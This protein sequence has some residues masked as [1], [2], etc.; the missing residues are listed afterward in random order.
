MN[1]LDI[2]HETY[3]ALVA[4]KVRTGLTMLGIVI[5]ISSVIAMVSIGQ[6]AQ[7]TIE[8]SIQSIGANLIMISP[9]AQA[10]VGGYQARSAGGSI[11]TLTSEDAL[12]I[13]ESVAGV[14][15]VTAELSGRYQVVA[16]GTNTNTSVVG[17]TPTY[18]EVRNIKMA[19]GAFLSD[20][21]VRTR[22]KVAVLGP[23]VRDTLFG[24]GAEAVGKTVRV[25]GMEFIVIGVTTAKGGSGFSNADDTMFIPLSSAQ[26][27]LAG[28]EHVSSISVQ[29]TDASVMT[30]AQAE[31]SAI[32]LKRHKIT[33]PAKADFSILNQNDIVATASSV[34]GIFTIL[35][36]AVAGISLV[37]GG[38]GIMN[39]ML[40]TV[41]ERTREIGLRKAIGAKKRDI[42][43]QFLFEA[44]A[45]TVVGG[46]IGVIIGWGI[47][48]GISYFNIIDTSVSLGS[49]LLA[50]GVS[51]FIGIVFGYYPAKRAA[52]L[53]PIEALRYE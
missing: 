48:F 31:V 39:M 18:P 15:S 33:D 51:A 11:R 27:F 35:L 38:I 49:V 36:G 47:S 17:T 30:E 44:I 13:A 28:S 14:Q 21:Q 52:E 6:G 50:F 5:G 22:A 2:L 41:T 7:K 43:R 53:N 4:N 34:T 46:T 20:L 9:G 12:A 8:T 29:A 23:T 10:S 19:E 40:T 16:K 45:L 25:N 32:L 26:Q 42:S 24:E 3:S 37:V 1:I